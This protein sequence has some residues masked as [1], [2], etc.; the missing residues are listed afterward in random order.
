MLLPLILQTLAGASASSLSTPTGLGVSRPEPDARITQEAAS[1]LASAFSVMR[2]W[3]TAEPDRAIPILERG[4]RRWQLR[5]RFI[6][7]LSM[8]AHPDAAA[9]LEQFAQDQLSSPDGDLQVL[10]EVAAALGKLHRAS[11]VRVLEA[12]AGHPGVGL[13]THRTATEAKNAIT[14]PQTDPVP[15]VDED[16][17]I[18]HLRLRD[19][20]REYSDWRV[21]Q[22][23]CAYAMEHI[24]GGEV[25]PGLV[26]ALVQALGHDQTFAR[27]AVAQCLGRID[28]ADAWAALLEE[29]R[30]PSLPAEVRKAC[31]DGVRRQMSGRPDR[32]DASRSCQPRPMGGHLGTRG[33]CG[34]R[35]RR[36]GR[37]S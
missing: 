7:A 31:L 32:G 34:G 36:A 15:K 9:A 27:T 11:S 10:C 16:E 19:T 26:A 21:I 29:L 12:I 1:S 23:Y 28:G 35:G 4:L 25:S 6:E 37:S 3:R 8:Y 18:A 24:S 20:H 17:I 13:R 30:E 5:R 14:W 33:R 22:Q 2:K